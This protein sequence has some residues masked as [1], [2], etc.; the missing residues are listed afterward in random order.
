MQRQLT[1]IQLHN[2]KH[3]TNPY[4]FTAGLLMLL[5]FTSKAQD[6]NDK[7]DENQSKT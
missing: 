5:A 6:T 7:D 1:V 3:E 4:F 2:N